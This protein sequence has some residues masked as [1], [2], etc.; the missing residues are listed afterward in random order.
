MTAD[1]NM[2]QRRDTINL[3]AFGVAIILFGGIVFWRLAIAIIFE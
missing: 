1:K 2:S 3:V